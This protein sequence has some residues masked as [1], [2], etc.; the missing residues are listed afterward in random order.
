MAERA[1]TLMSVDDFLSWDDGTDTRY[2]L[3]DGALR[4]TAPPDAAHRII[5]A[6]TTALIHVALRARQPCRPEIEAGL[7]IDDRTMWQA[8]VAVSCHPPAREIES[9]LLIV[10]ALSPSTRI[11]DLGRKLTDYRT[12][13]SVQEIWLVD[14]ERRWLQ[15]WRRDGERWIV[16]DFVGGSR[17][18]SAVLQAELSL[19]EIYA[20]SGI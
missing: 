10:E 17:F 12:L 14:S 11:H 7:R 1:L 20:N 6:N 13:A 4:A 2:E 5:V 15:L 19:D 8:D 16:Q 3:A 18:G 9:P